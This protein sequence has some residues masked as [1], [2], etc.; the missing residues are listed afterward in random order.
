MFSTHPKYV[1][2]HCNYE[3]SAALFAV[4]FLFKSKWERMEN[5]H[6]GFIIHVS[7]A[8]VLNKENLSLC[9]IFG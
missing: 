6:T 3:S 8:L 1:Y 9:R 2:R 5:K 4:F 7:S